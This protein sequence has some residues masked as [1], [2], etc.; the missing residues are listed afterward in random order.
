MP[1]PDHHAR[2]ERA[3]NEQAPSSIVLVG[4][5]GTGK[6]T[7]GPIVADRLEFRFVDTDTLIE[8]QHGPIPE[9]FKTRGE[10]AFRQIE[11]D[12]IREL[13]EIEGL[14]IATGGGTMLDE[15]NVTALSPSAVFFT[16][17]ASAR[18]I[19]DR[20]LIEGAVERP[21]LQTEHPLETIAHLLG[22]RHSTY[23]RFDQID[24]EARTPSDIADEIIERF[25]ATPPPSAT[26]TAR[27]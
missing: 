14:V 9:L 2:N 3:D 22:E 10:E 13:A 12:V 25:T 8:T 26:G 1:A 23:G 20:V 11:C 7:V 27:D 15:R 17:T 16:L 21:L 4:F 24:T 19:A 5:M 18:S 6:S